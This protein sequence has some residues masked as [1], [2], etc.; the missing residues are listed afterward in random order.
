M[1]LD[2][3]LPKLIYLSLFS[4]D[5]IIDFLFPLKKF[6]FCVSLKIF[7]CSSRRS[8]MGFKCSPDIVLVCLISSTRPVKETSL[9]FG[10]TWIHIRFYSNKPFIRT[11]NVIIFTKF[12]I[13]GDE[14]IVLYPRRQK[15]HWNL[16]SYTPLSWKCK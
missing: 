10:E 12:R 6:L 8:R 16:E 4:C 9:P 15:K 11:I 5:Q 13:C 2:L 3:N 7:P 1:S 14:T